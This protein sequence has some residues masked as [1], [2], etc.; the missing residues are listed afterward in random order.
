MPTCQESSL[1]VWPPADLPVCS[2]RSED[3]TRLTLFLPTSPHL[4]VRLLL[5]QLESYSLCVISLASS[6]DLLQQRGLETGQK[7]NAEL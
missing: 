7:H 1:C 3:E 5:W 6:G 4:C 2:E